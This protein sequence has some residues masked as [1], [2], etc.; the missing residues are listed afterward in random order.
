MPEQDF[1]QPERTEEVVVTE[2]VKILVINNAGNGF[3][4]FKT[5]PS[6][7]KYSEVF[8][9]IMGPDAK[10]EDFT[11]RVNANVVSTEDGVTHKDKLSITSAVANPN[12]RL[13]V[14]PKKVAG[15]M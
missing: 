5:F 4:E 11:I 6:G 9:E 10:P 7:T 12:D 2:N 1:G 8:K 15:A 3:A 14:A 13:T